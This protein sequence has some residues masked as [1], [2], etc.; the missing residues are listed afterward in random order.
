[1]P[2]E[3]LRDLRLTPAPLA[4]EPEPPIFHPLLDRPLA[5]PASATT[6]PSGPGG[7]LRR[8]REPGFA[9]VAGAGH[10]RR[11]F[12]Y[13]RAIYLAQAGGRTVGRQ[14]HPSAL[15]RRGPFRAQT[16][17]RRKAVGARAPILVEAKPNA[18][19][20]TDFVHDQ[21]ANG[22]RFRILNIVD[23]VTKQCLGAMPDTSISGRRVRVS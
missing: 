22:R 21:F 17:S 9:P 5:K 4:K 12:G 23:D 7:A 2:I 14:P 6:T 18:R 20:S 10:E 19:W 15:S 16:E 1:M 11:R 13:R 3:A 8:T